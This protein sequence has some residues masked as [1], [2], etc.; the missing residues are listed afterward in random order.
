MTSRAAKRRAK[1]DRQA[2]TDSMDL[3]PVPR[4]RKAGRARM[5]EIRATPQEDASLPAIAARCRRAGKEMNDDTMRDMRAPW[6]GC[7]AGMAMAREVKTEAE[8]VALW[9][10]I[11]HVRMTYTR[12]ARTE[13]LPIR[14]AQCL[15]ILVPTDA[16]H[17]DAASPAI[18]LRSVEE[19]H[20]AA[21]RSWRQVELLLSRRGRA[22][23]G[24]A[25][26]CIL[27]DTPCENATAMVLALRNVSDYVGP[28]K[29]A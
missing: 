26:R 23:E 10:A 5:A 22:T 27:D 9:G 13:G 18:D 19:R 21:E 12:Y 2:T 15:R 24:I 3:A 28:T 8:R 29:S 16:M 11:Q 1:R 20:A 6:N 17:A 14:S 4:K 7:E 25:K